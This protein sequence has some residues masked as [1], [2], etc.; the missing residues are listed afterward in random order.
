MATSFLAGLAGKTAHNVL[1]QLGAKGGER[2][3]QAFRKIFGKAPE[4]GNEIP[5]SDMKAAV[6]K[7]QDLLDHDVVLREAIVQVLLAR[8]EPAEAANPKLLRLDQRG[9]SFSRRRR[10]YPK[11]RPNRKHR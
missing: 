3:Y 8:L 11:G 4:A 1:S 5:E 9:P 2:C 10:Q 6:P 7:I